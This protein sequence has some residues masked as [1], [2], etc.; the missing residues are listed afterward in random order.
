MMYPK[1]IIVLSFSM[2]LLFTGCKEIPKGDLA[3][4]S[5]LPEAEEK[6]INTRELSQEFKDYWYAGNAEITS[7]KLKQARY[8]ELR[9]GTA[10]TIFV[11]EDFL[12]E[13]QVKANNQSKA[14]IPVLKLNSTKNFL[15]G[16]YPYSIMTS[17]FNPVTTKEH[18]LKVSNSVQ[19]WCGHVYAQLNNK[20]DFEITAHSYFEGEGDQQIKL[21][22]TWL[23]NELWNLIRINPNELPTGEAEIIPSFDY[24]RLGHKNLKAYRA[25]LSL[26]QLESLQVYT[27]RYPE[28]NRD[29]TIYF[30]TEFPFSIEKWEETYV[31]GYGQG[32]KTLTTTATK[33]K[34][35][36]TTYWSQN[37]NSDSALRDTLGLD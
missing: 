30:E 5:T 31:S 12:P 20:K 29:L 17:T 32:A 3:A 8:G 36:K 34:Q 11:T 26:E 27:I 1:F 28:L 6:I 25:I 7:Y 14:N 24:L 16:V 10:V 19:E 22:K 15:T 33:M 18:A 37:K 35:I 23:E 4:L 13:A 2:T 9:A 21:P